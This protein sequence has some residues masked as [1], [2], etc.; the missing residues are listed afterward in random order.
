MIFNRVTHTA[1]GGIIGYSGLINQVR[2]RHPNNAVDMSE[3][4]LNLIGIGSLA[5]SVPLLAICIPCY[6][7]LHK[8]FTGGKDLQ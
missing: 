2:A 4:I 8:H 3:V 5:L 6:N 1:E 7:V